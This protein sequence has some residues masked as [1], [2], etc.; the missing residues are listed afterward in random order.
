MDNA[1][2]H[3]K[4]EGFAILCEGQMDVIKAWQSSLK[5]VVCT[6]GTNITQEQVKLLARFTGRVYLAMD[7]DSAG[8]GSLHR[9]FSLVKKM[10]IDCYVLQ[11]D[12][13]VKDLDEFFDNSGDIDELLRCAVPLYEFLIKEIYSS[14]SNEFD[15]DAALR[16]LLNELKDANDYI[17]RQVELNYPTITGRIGLDKSMGSFKN[18]SVSD[19]L[20]LRVMGIISILKERKISRRLLDRLDELSEALVD[21]VK[22]DEVT[23]EASELEL[24]I[25]QADTTA[26]LIRKLNLEHNLRRLKIALLKEERVESQVRIIN[27]I[28]KIIGEVVSKR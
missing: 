8:K 19:N 10:E 23:V 21:Q 24:L 2:E 15:Q 22:L 25:E 26:E 4:Q 20:S 7:N 5:N 13:G 16:K 27:E 14:Y 3:I 17:K 9:F 28:L 6:S 1:K 11:F 18:Q 12:R